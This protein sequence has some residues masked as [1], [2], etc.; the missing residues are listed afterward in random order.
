[1]SNWVI[2]YIYPS[3]GHVVKL[4]NIPER[5]TDKREA[6]ANVEMLNAKRKDLNTFY[7]IVEEK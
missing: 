2:K 4:D 1:M 3:G 7:I 5:F 6:E